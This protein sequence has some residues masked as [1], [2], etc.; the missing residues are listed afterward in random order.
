VAVVPVLLVGKVLVEMDTLGLMVLCMLVVEVVEQDRLEVFSRAALV[1][2][3]MG[4]YIL[5]PAL[6]L[7]VLLVELILV[8]VEVVLLL[9]QA[10][11]LL[12]VVLEDLV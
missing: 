3:A 10:V 11:A 2:E 8:V 12:V 1:V 5:E 9:S 4:P 6:V 7:L